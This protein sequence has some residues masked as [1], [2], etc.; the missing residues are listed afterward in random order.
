MGKQY[1]D[2]N[3]DGNDD[4]LHGYAVLSYFLKQTS[5]YEV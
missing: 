3:T 1:Q 5:S 4:Q 2:I